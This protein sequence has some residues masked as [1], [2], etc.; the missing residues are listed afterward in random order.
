MAVVLV[1]HPV[2]TSTWPVISGV[3]SAPIGMICT[4]LA[5]MLFLASRARSRMMPVDWMPI[6]LPTMSCAV[7]I[8][9]F[10]SEKKQ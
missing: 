3:M 9:F 5:S 6:Y 2:T 1:S 7:R 4:S 10:F 8:G